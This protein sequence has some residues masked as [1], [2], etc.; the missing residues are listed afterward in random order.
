[1]FFH[2]TKGGVLPD[3]MAYECNM[4]SGNVGRECHFLGGDFDGAQEGLTRFEKG[5]SEVT[6]GKKYPE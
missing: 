3:L 6:R 5:Q 4:M 2:T 1:M